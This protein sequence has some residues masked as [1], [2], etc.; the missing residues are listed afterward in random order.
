ME[1][2]TLHMKNLRQFFVFQFV[3]EIRFIINRQWNSYAFVRM[4]SVL[5]L[6]EIKL[7]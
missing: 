1:M 3:Y 5:F 2:T 7:P 4:S 6:K